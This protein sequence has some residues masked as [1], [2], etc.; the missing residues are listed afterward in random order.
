MCGRGLDY[1]MTEKASPEA[2]RDMWTRSPIS[3]A[4]QVFDVLSVFFSVSVGDTTS[5]ASPLI[6]TTF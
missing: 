1:E 5:L 3:H 4:D 6:M 2:Y